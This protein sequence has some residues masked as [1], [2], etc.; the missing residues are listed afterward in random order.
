MADTQQHI[1]EP[2][3]HGIWIAAAFILALLALVVALVGLNRS[4]TASATME[5]E[6]LML[7][8]KIE[9]LHAQAPAA[10]Q[11]VR[12]APAAVPEAPMEK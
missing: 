4:S 8:K 3:R 12:P 7:N 5:L 6:I 9:A 11:P 2:E 10:T 1:I